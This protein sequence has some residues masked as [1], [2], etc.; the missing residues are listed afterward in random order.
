MCESIEGIENNFCA[1][2]NNIRGVI[3]PLSLSTIHHCP[4]GLC[5]FG[6]VV[7][8]IDSVGLHIYTIF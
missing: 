7:N 1:N 8:K 6:G 5:L 3:I 4:N 2:R